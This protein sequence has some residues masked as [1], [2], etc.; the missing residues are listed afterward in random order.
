MKNAYMAQADE[1]ARR[2]CYAWVGIPPKIV[3]QFDAERRR[4]DRMISTLGK[5]AT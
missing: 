4:R 5:W 2:A 3:A 1:E